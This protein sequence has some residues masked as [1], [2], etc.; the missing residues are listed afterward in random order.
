MTEPISVFEC[1][2]A[3]Q[4]ITLP[5]MQ[6]DKWSEAR[7][8]IDLLHAIDWFTGNGKSTDNG[9]VYLFLVASEYL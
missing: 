1:N 2:L 9:R 8:F 5:G 4:E 7:C 3:V 6:S